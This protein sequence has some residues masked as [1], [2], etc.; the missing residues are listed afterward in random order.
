MRLFDDCGITFQDVESLIC[1]DDEYTSYGASGRLILRMFLLHDLQR[2][3][4]TSLY[5]VAIS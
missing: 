3:N 5:A 4:T 1:V 2:R